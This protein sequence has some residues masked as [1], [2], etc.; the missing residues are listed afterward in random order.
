ME[1][2]EPAQ[3]PVEATGSHPCSRV[4]RI[5]FANRCQDFSVLWGARP[6][7]TPITLS[8][9]PSGK[10]TTPDR[11]VE[12]NQTN[13]AAT[14]PIASAT[15]ILARSRIIADISKFDRSVR[16]FRA[17]VVYPARNRSALAQLL[18]CYGR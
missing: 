18:Q 11:K 5:F 13:S 8:V 16:H 12:T 6:T 17:D 1:F 2:D 9:E 15:G 7:V 3:V 10:R 14:A 4:G